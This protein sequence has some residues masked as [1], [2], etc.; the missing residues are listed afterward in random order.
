MSTTFHGSYVEQL[1]NGVLV[2]THALHSPATSDKYY[3]GGIEEVIQEDADAEWIKPGMTVVFNTFA[4]EQ[5]STTAV[6][7]EDK[8]IAGE[9]YHMWGQHSRDSG[10][11]TLI[12]LGVWMPSEGRRSIRATLLQAIARCIDP[13]DVGSRNPEIIYTKCPNP[14]HGLKEDRLMKERALDTRTTYKS[15]C[16]FNIVMEGMC[17]E[18]LW[19]VKDAANDNFGIPED[20]NA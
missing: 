11:Q 15:L 20:L 3:C 8:P 16:L 13:R 18:C 1:G 7:I 14:A 12:D 19:G 17:S 10:G 9:V 2:C 4:H 5:D 6:K